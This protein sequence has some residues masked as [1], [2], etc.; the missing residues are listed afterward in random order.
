MLEH[1]KRNFNQRN[2]NKRDIEK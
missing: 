2:G 1:K